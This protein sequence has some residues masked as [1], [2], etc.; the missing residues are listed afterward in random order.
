MSVF[1]VAALP[2]REGDCLVLSWGPAEDQLSHMVVDAGHAE[3]APLLLN[4]LS[5]AGVRHIELIVV[6]HV[7]A[8]HIEGMLDFL[9]AARKVF[10]I[11]DV[12][13]NGYRHLRDG[14]EGF[15]PVQGELLTMSISDLP[16][17]RA[18][19]G[20]AI[21]AADDGSPRLIATLAGLGITVISPDEAKLKAMVPTWEADV[22]AAGLEP[23]RVRVE[24]KVPAGLEAL[25]AGIDVLAATRTGKDTARANGTSIAFIAEYDGMRV[26]LGADAHPGILERGLRSLSGDGKLPIDLV[27][28]PH[29]G[30]QNNVSRELLQ[31][32]DCRRFLIST[33]GTKFKHPDPIALA[34]IIASQRDGVEL[35]FNYRQPRALEWAENPE[36]GR[37]YRCVFPDSGMPLVID[38]RDHPVAARR[39]MAGLAP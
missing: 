1:R 32:M 6:T 29:H 9:P 25:G 13:F 34:R 28:V 22:R 18:A 17:N 5:D 20:R 12:W 39:D 38:V 24:T 11:G 10:Q 4:Y 15:G 8:D 23:G 16:W 2:A 31:R 21:R 14:L 30:S 7:D 37:R 19:G 36:A 3:T 35:F 33:D 26:L 27:K